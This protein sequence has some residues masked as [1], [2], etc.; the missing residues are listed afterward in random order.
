[1]GH[2]APS[3]APFYCQNCLFLGTPSC[4]TPTSA[5]YL[6]SYQLTSPHPSTAGSATLAL[7]EVVVCPEP[8]GDE[9]PLSSEA[10]AACNVCTSFR[11]EVTTEE[12]QDKGLHP[13][14]HA[15]GLLLCHRLAVQPP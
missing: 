11:G 3:T 8:S 10:M 1:M 2:D 14:V 9:Q 7:T 13:S 15:Y 5:M 4:L 12:K 6:G